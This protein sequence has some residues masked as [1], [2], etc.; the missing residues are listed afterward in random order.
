MRS[1]RVGEEV[2]GRDHRRLGTVERLVVDEQAHRVTHLVVAGRLLGV[3]RVSDADGARLVADI[4]RED[5]AGQPEAR[6]ELVTEPGGHWRA[7]GGYS[8]RDFLAIA[9]ALVGQ[10]PYVPPVHLDVDL[11]AV[12][13]IAPGS[14]VFSGNDHVGDV[15]QVLTDDGGQ[16]TSLVLRRPGVR[17][18]R[19]QL[20]PDRVTEV[21]GTAVHV[22]LTAEEVEGLPE[23]EDPD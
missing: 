18:R 5:L 8:L 9:S 1:L 2:L 19:V 12:H 23:Y 15:S 11:S 6:P 16:V 7:P 21:V 4:A 3:G 20:A 14:P 10:G 17:G 13:E 22:S